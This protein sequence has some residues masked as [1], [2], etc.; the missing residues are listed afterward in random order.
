MFG[1]KGVSISGGEPLLTLDKTLKYLKAVK[2]KHGDEVHM[3]MYTNGKLI[4]PDVLEKLKKAGL[5]EI[6][7]DIGAVNYELEKI[8]LAASYIPVVTVEIPAIPEDIDMI[9]RILPE[10]VSA[11]AQYLNLHQLRA[12][13]W[14]ISLLLKHNYTFS[15]GPRVLVPE[16]ELTA[17]EIIKYSLE[18]RIPV[19]V[20]YCSFIYKNTYQISAA[21]TRHASLIIR[22]FE[23]MTETGLI[24]Q[25]S[26]TGTEEEISKLKEWI[27]VI[28]AKEEEVFTASEGK[29][30]YLPERFL[31]VVADLRLNC[32][33]NYGASSIQPNITYRNIF[34]EIALVK[35]RKVFVEKKNLSGDIIIQA[36]ELPFFIESFYPYIST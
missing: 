9:K 5:E 32:T 35:G 1:F 2:D 13:K 15:H 31:R 36:D 25:I 29:K 23:D 10:L 26:V 34:R 19:S 11:G 7:I 8:K 30:I 14:N 16:S 12:T 3:W 20:N 33:V 18:N 17:L 24:R 27:K 4:T 22:P 28:H 6:R 21:R